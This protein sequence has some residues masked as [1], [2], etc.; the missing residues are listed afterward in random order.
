VAEIIAW[1]LILI[2]ISFPQKPEIHFDSQKFSFKGTSKENNNEYA[3]ELEFYG[4]VEPEVRISV[5]KVA[6][7]TAAEKRSMQLTL[8]LIEI[9]AEL[10]CTQPPDG[11]L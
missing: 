11:H 8:F 5:V 4:E 7:A 9:Q 10:D 3:V 2:F 6:C 1:K